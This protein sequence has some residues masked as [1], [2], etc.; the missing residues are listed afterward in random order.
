M[1]KK[2]IYINAFVMSTPV[3]QS[4]GLWAHPDNQSYTYTKPQFW[5]ALA[6]ICEA[7][8]FDAIF[9]ADVLGVYDVYKGDR[10]T[11]IQHGVQAPVTDPMMNVP[12]M[13]AVTKHIGFGITSSVLHEHPYTFARRMSTLDHLT[14]GR[15]GWNIV[16]GY[17]KSGVTNMGMDDQLPHDERYEIAEEYVQVVKKLWEDSWEDDAVKADKAN[18]LYTDPA[19]VHDINHVGNYYKVPGA[20][21]CEPSP[22]RTPVIF[23]A[24]ASDRG[25]DFATKHAELMFIGSPTMAAT[26]KV[27]NNIRQKAKE[28]G[29]DPDSVKIVMIMTPI[30]ADTA[31]AAKSKYESFVKYTHVEAAAALFGGW[32]GIDLDG[33]DPNAT[34]AYIEND[35]MR[36]AIESFTKAD[37]SRQWT[38][39]EIAKWIGIGG[40][41]PKLI[42]DP[43]QVADM[44]EDWV[45][46]TGIDGFNIAS[47][48]IPG[49]FKD[50]AEL[51]MPILQARGR[52]PKTYTGTSF[53]DNLF[54]AG[55]RLKK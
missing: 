34:M 43:V 49:T 37:P 19:K 23:Q 44:I 17:L 25:L 38:F 4:P 40:R 6:Q 28:Q 47:A 39:G 41:G 8:R 30:V 1:T 16:T 54:G 42:G 15:I 33:V 46:Q 53:R 52:V 5:T 3:H 45:E 18:N 29:R 14:Q 35:A 26:K 48:I 7:A 10:N 51:V 32:T 9:L 55:D 12:Y 21:L 2:R 50:F 27:V 22:Q 31:A 13:A 36:S 20:H 24:G 11:A